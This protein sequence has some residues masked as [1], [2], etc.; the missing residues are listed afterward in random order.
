MPYDFSKMIE[1]LEP[2]D[3][4]IFIMTIHDQKLPKIYELATEDDCREVVLNAIQD[5][6]IKPETAYSILDKYNIMLYARGKPAILLSLY[7]DIPDI[8]KL[9]EK[10]SDQT[11]NF[12]KKI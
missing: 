4:N 3:H 11:I 1:N 8:D 6:V 2:H 12:K 9:K 7:Y 10:I 5:W